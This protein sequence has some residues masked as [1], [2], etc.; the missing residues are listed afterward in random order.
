MFILFLFFSPPPYPPS[1]T[2]WS[3][4]PIRIDNEASWTNER[5]SWA[6]RTCRQFHGGKLVQKLRK[7]MFI[8]VNLIS[9]TKCKISF[10]KN[11]WIKKILFAQFSK[12]VCVGNISSALLY[13]HSH[14][15]T[16]TRHINT[17]TYRLCVSLNT[18]TDT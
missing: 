11:P 9:I 18:D 17:Y 5:P 15:H 16:N 7:I 12:C 10:S 3:R 2:P 1:T 8:I 4:D 14:T 13:S 6:H